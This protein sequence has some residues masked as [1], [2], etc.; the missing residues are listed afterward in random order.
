M[1]RLVS[2]PTIVL[3]IAQ[4]YEIAFLCTESWAYFVPF[5]D[6]WDVFLR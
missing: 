2:K 3:P 6:Q 4:I 5:W 1:G